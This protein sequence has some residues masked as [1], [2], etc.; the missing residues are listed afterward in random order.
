VGVLLLTA[1]VS[2]LRGQYVTQN[3]PP[4][5][6]QHVAAFPID[7]IGIYLYFNGLFYYAVHIPFCFSYSGGILEIYRVTCIYCVLGHR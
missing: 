5:S 3:G 6:A 4:S 1:V 7:V 2:T